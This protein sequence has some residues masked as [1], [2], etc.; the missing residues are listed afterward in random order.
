MP[1]LRRPAW[2]ADN[3]TLALVA[4]V[5]LASVVPVGGA[6][7]RWFDVA[8]ALLVALLFFLHGAKL[9]SEAVVAGLLHWRLHLVVLACTFVL[10]PLLGLALQPLLGGLVTPE[11]YLGVLFLCVLPST[12]QSSIAFVSVARGNVAAAVCSASASNLLGMFLTPL[13]AGLILSSQ[14]G[15]GTTISLD[16]V[17]KITLQLLLPFVAG[18]VA[19]RW[20]GGWVAR[21]K[22]LTRF[23]DQGTIVLVVYTAFSAAV[24]EGLW[25]DVPPRYLLGLVV[26]T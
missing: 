2:L 8:T 3:F 4:A 16:A 13:L 18:Q 10:M 26:I 14:G 9:S 24:I 23:S 19:R 21:H 11:L 1:N 17:G 20:I 6:A 7:A 15:G 5:V 22:A 12:V 25:R